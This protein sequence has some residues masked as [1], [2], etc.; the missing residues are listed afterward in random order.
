M[1]K[2]LTLRPFIEAP[3]VQPLGDLELMLQ[4]PSGNTACYICLCVE[5]K[6]GRSRTKE[7]VKGVLTAL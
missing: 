5:N 2:S 7:E 4:L 6:G 3:A 1:K